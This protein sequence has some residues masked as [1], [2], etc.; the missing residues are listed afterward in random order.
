MQKPHRP[1]SC[2]TQAAG[3]ASDLICLHQPLGINP[4]GWKSDTWSHKLPNSL[5]WTR[6][7]ACTNSCP[8]GWPAWGVMVGT[9]CFNFSVVSFVQ[10][11]GS[12][13]DLRHPTWCRG[14]C[15]IERSEGTALF[16]ERGLHLAE[17]A[18]GASRSNYPKGLTL[19]MQKTVLTSNRHHDAPD[20][21]LVRISVEH[22]KYSKLTSQL[23][24]GIWLLTSTHCC[25]EKG[26]FTVTLVVPIQHGEKRRHNGSVGMVLRHWKEEILAII[27]L[28]M[29]GTI[30]AEDLAQDFAI[31][32]SQ[33][34]YQTLVEV[35]LP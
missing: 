25:A 26:Q 29:K 2:L 1:E 19:G 35:I 12:A 30:S 5:W 28:P 14:N 22:R 6:P 20:H 34:Y 13:T 4:S 18:P 21:G 32:V 16:R 15:S 17:P 27:Q 10:V 23:L 31:E 24:R 9:S 7:C 11:Q 3:N 8:A 33:H